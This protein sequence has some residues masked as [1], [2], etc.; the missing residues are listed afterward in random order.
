MR[1]RCGSSILICLR[2][3]LYPNPLLL[4]MK[5]L[6]IVDMVMT[7]QVYH[8]PRLPLSRDIVLKAISDPKINHEL[9]PVAS[10]R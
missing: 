2:L 4:Q 6:L 10:T 5:V 8:D 9:V 7:L 1:A 3:Y